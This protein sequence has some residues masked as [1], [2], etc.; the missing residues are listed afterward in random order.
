MTYFFVHFLIVRERMTNSRF[1]TIGFFGFLS[2]RSLPIKAKDVKG[3][4]FGKPTSG[5]LT[6]GTGK[7]KPVAVVK[8][9]KVQAKV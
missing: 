6:K 1:P 7:A 9:K 3:K 4:K 8:A 2:C 5:K